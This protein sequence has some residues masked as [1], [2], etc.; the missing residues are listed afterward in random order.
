M[1]KKYTVIAVW[2]RGKVKYELGI[3]LDIATRR[4]TTS[5]KHGTRSLH[6][7]ILGRSG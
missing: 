3:I 6:Q 5:T 7:L 2:I 4:F 1:K